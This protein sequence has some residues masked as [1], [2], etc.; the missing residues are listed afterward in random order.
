[1]GIQASSR[2]KARGTRFPHP[3][4]GL[5]VTV[6]LLSLG[7]VGLAAQT[8]G[9][10]SL[11]PWQPSPEASD[12]VKE[13]VG[14]KWNVDPTNLHLEW[15][16][17]RNGQALSEVEGLEIFGGG[18][19]G[20]WIVSFFAP[21]SPGQRTTVPLRAGVTLNQPVA[22]IPLARG[23]VLESQHIEYQPHVQWGPPEDGPPP[24][25]PG[26]VAQRRIG[27]GE[28]LSAPGVRPPLLVV[29]GRPVRIIWSSGALKI[30]LEGN[31]VGS[32]ALGEQ[33]FVRTDGG[34]RM[35]GVVTGPGTVLL[36]STI[37]GG[38]K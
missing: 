35:Q 29:S 28:L 33:V 15:G 32:A 21:G 31:A 20:Q 6:L 36:S 13:L 23:D 25:E 26:W 9:G 8:E 1:M 7:R 2:S 11:P 14:T 22:R 4:L 37:T 12:H 30:S 38:L 10:D 16:R 27:A 18:R 19:N 5:W 24:V 34:H 3:R 17:P